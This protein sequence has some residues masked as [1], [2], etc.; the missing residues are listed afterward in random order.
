MGTAGA[1][2]LGIA[3][4]PI[5]ALAVAALLG[6]DGALRAA[7]AFVVGEAVAVGAI[8]AIVVTLAA[9]SLED[10]LDVTVAV[11]QLAIAG[12]LGLL[13]VAHMQRAGDKRATP[14]VLAALNGVRERP[15]AAFVIGLAMVAVNPKNLAFA[16]A[17]GAAILQ[18]DR[19]WGVNLATV[20]A[21]T[22]LAVS[23]LTAEIVAYALSPQRAAR[24]L[25]R[26]GA[27][28]SRHERVL[29]SVVLIGLA[30]LFFTRG[31]LDMLR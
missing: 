31:L 12:L 18:L 22:A 25:A 11:M 2:A 17:G 21:F 23:V 6:G 16:L 7:A 20:V 27:L 8:A 1:A 30:V 9:S 4:S 15:R 5:P 26:G 14:R 24:L 29:V 10:S 3:V 28:A 13:L 19:T